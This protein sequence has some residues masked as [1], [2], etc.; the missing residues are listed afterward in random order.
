MVEER[1]A[2]IE[3]LDETKVDDRLAMITMSSTPG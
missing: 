3:H 1:H 2:F